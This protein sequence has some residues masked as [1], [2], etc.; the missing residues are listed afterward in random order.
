[1]ESSRSFLDDMW[2]VEVL[3]RFVIVRAC[4]ACSSTAVSGSTVLETI[5]NP[6]SRLSP[7]GHLLSCSQKENLHSITRV[8]LD[9]LI[10]RLPPYSE[11]PKTGV[12]EEQDEQLPS[13]SR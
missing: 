8:L 5:V 4:A 1:M 10:K 3:A 11:L 13:S 12:A 9:L 2:W 7:H 6:C